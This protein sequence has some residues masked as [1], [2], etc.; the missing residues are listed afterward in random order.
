[1]GAGKT[2]VGRK[3]AERLGRSFVDADEELERRTGSTIGD[4]FQKGEE[5]FRSVEEEIVADLLRGEPAVLALGGGAVLSP[6]TRQHLSRRAVSVLLEVDPA[7]AWQRVRN[8]SRPLA[9]G[10][11]A[12]RALYEERRP[13]YEEV[14]DAVARDADD[15]VL[16]AAG[17]TVGIGSLESLGSLVPGD[18][19][20]ALVA[21]RHVA[22]I[23][24]ASVQPELG[25]RLAS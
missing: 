15:A 14:A 11:E 5:G 17:I 4:L 21:D 22:G 7:K 1:M 8:S 9:Q 10:E 18:G 6:A 12:F 3:V 23:Y 20:V 13:V 16:G 19:P 2:T 24:G 25:R